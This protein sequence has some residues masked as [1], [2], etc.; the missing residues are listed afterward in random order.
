MSVCFPH[1]THFFGLGPF[2]ILLSIFLMG[3]II[4]FLHFLLVFYVSHRPI[5]DLAFT[6]IPYFTSKSSGS[7]VKLTFLGG[8]PK[9]HGSYKKECTRKA[10]NKNIAQCVGTN[11]QTCFESMLKNVKKTCS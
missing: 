9:H 7:Y 8:Y 10:K 2:F 3:V 6:E 4:N 1:Y 11:C 5:F